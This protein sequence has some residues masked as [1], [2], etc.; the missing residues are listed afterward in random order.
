MAMMSAFRMKKSKSKGILATET[1]VV[2]FGSISG[3]GMLLEAVA[4][5]A[6]LLCFLLLGDMVKMVEKISGGVRKRVLT[7]ENG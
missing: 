6:F 1:G 2:G 3:V 7:L 4:D 5:F